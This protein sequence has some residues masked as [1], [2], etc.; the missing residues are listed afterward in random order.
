MLFSSLSTRVQGADGSDADKLRCLPTI[1]RGGGVVQ[2]Y[3]FVILI[4]DATFVGKICSMLTSLMRQ[5]RC[6]LVVF[7]YISLRSIQIVTDCRQTANIGNQTC[8]WCFVYLLL[9]FFSRVRLYPMEL[10][11]YVD[12]T[13]R[14]DVLLLFS[15]FSLYCYCKN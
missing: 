8:R 12:R 7:V 5:R 1:W 14:T 6:R 15:V 3:I 2:F 11:T 9:M 4:S 10:S 13:L